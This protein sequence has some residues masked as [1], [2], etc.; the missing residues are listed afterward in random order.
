MSKV[1]LYIARHG[2]TMF[3]TIGR[4]QGWSDTPLTTFGE[5]GIKE[6]GL[7]LKASNISFKEA[8][9]S[10]SGRTLQTMEIILREVQQENIPYTRDK[11]IREWCFDIPYTRDKRIR[12]W[13]F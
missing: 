5:L 11:R 12:E 8:F 13:C 3:N 1:R 2:K 10:D 7:G 9:S 6:L 4:A